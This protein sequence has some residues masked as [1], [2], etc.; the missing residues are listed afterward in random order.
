MRERGG[1]AD[2]VDHAAVSVV[3]EVTVAHLSQRL[4]VREFG[5]RKDALGYPQSSRQ[6]GS[7]GAHAAAQREETERGRGAHMGFVDRCEP[8]HFLCQGLDLFFL[9]KGLGFEPKRGSVCVR[10]RAR[11]SV[12][13]RVYVCVCVCLS[14]C[15][16][17]CVCVCERER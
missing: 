16:G 10:E 7:G 14:V 4:G 5:A 17:V 2:P 12:C 8:A 13:V 1:G 6:F 3:H 15:V 9:N 11:R